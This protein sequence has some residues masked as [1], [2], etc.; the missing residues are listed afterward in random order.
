MSLPVDGVSQPLKPTGRWLES[1][2]AQGFFGGVGG[3][4]GSAYDEALCFLDVFAVV[5]TSSLTATLCLI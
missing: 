1:S 2:N 4:F 3:G 5:E